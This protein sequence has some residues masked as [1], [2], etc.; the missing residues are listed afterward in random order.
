MKHARSLGTA[1][2]LAAGL[3]VAGCTSTTPPATSPAGE[4]AAV[5]ATATSSNDLQAEITITDPWVKATDTD[6]TGAFGILTNNTDADIHV[7]AVTSTLSER[8][9]LHETVSQ[10]GS[11]VMQEMADGF[12]IAAGE[13]FVLE[14]GGNHLMLMN[15]TAPIE[16][17][18][19]V[20][21]TLEFEGGGTFSWLAP[22]R[23][24]AGA[25]EEYREREGM[26]SSSPTEG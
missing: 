25:Q 3:A 1:V 23:T 12:V 4:S 8:A 20:E 19:D 17:G 26:P 10:D 13:E 6:M 5:S 2:A 11:M 7:V 21:L 16:A 9:E 15:L 22:A 18:M 24:F 14:P